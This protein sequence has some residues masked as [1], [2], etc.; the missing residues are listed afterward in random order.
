M[1]QQEL[2]QRELSQQELGRLLSHWAEFCKSY[3][4]WLP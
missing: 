4:K 1:I 3:F 2:G